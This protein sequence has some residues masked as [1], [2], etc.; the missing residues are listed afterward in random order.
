L[1]V[2][3][4]SKRVAWSKVGLRVPGGARIG[5]VESSPQ[6]DEVFR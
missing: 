1:A 3:D 6:G 2:S 4:C 5:L